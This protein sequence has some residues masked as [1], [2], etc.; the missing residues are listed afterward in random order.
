MA[1]VYL[2]S[3]YSKWEVSRE[4]AKLL[5]EIFSIEDQKQRFN[6]RFRMSYATAYVRFYKRG[7]GLLPPGLV[8]VGVRGLRAQ[9][10]GV[11]VID[12]VKAKIP[13]SERQNSSIY[14][15]LDDNHQ[16]PALDALMK[17]NRGILQAATN[18]GKTRIMQAWCVLNQAKTLVLVPSKELLDQILESFQNNTNLDCG[19]ISATQGWKIGKDVTIGLVSS[20]ASTRGANPAISRFKEHA[21]AFEAVLVDECH[22]AQAKSWTMIFERLERCKYWYGFSG[23][24]W[25][26]SRSGQI[27]Y[28][29]KYKV[30][31]FL[32]EVKYTVT[33]SELIDRGWSSTPTINIVSYPTQ[34]FNGEDYH[35]IYKQ[36]IVNN[37]ERN[38]TIANIAQKRINSSQNVLIALRRPRHA[39]NLKKLLE[40]NCEVITGETDN[41]TRTGALK[42]FKQ[43]KTKILISTIL[44]E[45]VDIENIN[46]LILAGSGKAYK[47][48]LQVIGRGLRKK[49]GVNEIEIIDF[50]DDCNRMLEK[51]TKVRRAYYNKEGFYSKIV[52]ASEF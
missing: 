27:D 26:I 33:N 51:Q 52:S 5:T 35:D 19:Y 3:T 34:D 40:S 41:T 38:N 11:E 7:S 29:A 30:Q 14:V 10:Y 44:G 42:R 20:I 36:A 13:P 9:K 46:C 39:K 8:K 21:A 28:V 32:G 4:E 48:L 25:E 15:D 12:C 16:I 43:G 31:S 18:A 50:L 2:Y 6:P 49:K 24:P 45:G 22:H 37:T 23:T 17:D 47:Q 1:K